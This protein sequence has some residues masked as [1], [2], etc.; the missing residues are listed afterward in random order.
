MCEGH[1]VACVNL[2]HI[3]QL[4]HQ[5]F[6]VFMIDREEQVASADL[7]YLERL[8]AISLVRDALVLFG[9]VGEVW[10]KRTG[11]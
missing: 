10:W 6:I 5:V 8:A 7:G 1:R 3:F 2:H 9:G 4:K 11:W